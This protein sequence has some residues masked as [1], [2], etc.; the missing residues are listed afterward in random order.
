MG[1]RSSNGVF[2]LPD[3][4]KMR[5]GEKNFSFPLSS[6]RRRKEAP[7]LKPFFWYILERRA[8]QVVGRTGGKPFWAREKGGTIYKIRRRNSLISTKGRRKMLLPPLRNLLSSLVAS[9]RLELVEKEW[10][11]SKAPPPPRSEKGGRKRSTSREGG[12]RTTLFFLSRNILSSGIKKKRALSLPLLA[13]LLSSSLH[14][15]VKLRLE[16]YPSLLFLLP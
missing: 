15:T 13:S 5:Q 1:R 16:T 2:L 6:R 11:L 12:A 7:K 8:I 9:T 3:P 14:F 4:V 10:I